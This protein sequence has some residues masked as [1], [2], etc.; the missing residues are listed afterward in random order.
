MGFAD[1]AKDLA[2]GFAWIAVFFK[3]RERLVKRLPLGTGGCIAIEQV[4]FVKF[5]EPGE[6]L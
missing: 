2:P 6:E 5:G 1:L 3:F 4:G